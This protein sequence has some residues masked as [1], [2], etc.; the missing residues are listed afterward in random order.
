MASRRVV[1]GHK[2][3]NGSKPATYHGGKA[4]NFDGGLSRSHRMYRR[5]APLAASVA[6]LDD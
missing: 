1:F 6:P 4:L 5:G 3:H 2:P